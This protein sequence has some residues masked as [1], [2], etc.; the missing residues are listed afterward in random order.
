MRIGMIT[1]SLYESDNRVMRYAEALASRGDEVEVIALRKEGKP[2]EETIAGVRVF[3]VQSR[4][5]KEKKRASFLKQVLLFFIKASLLVSKRHLRRRYDLLHMHSIPDFLVFAGWMPKLMGAKVILDIHDILPE[6]Y[7]SKFGVG[8]Q[9][10]GF[11]TMLLLERASAAFSDHVILANHLWEQRFRSR[12]LARGGKCTV[13]LNYPDRSL[14][15]PIERNQL[16]DKFII[17]YPGTLNQHQGVDVAIRAFA[18]L[19]KT[20]PNAEFHIYGEGRT[21]DSLMSLVRS[22]NLG[23]GVRFKPMLPIRDIALVMANSDLAV[24]PKR[25]DSFGNEAFSTKIFEFMSVGVPVIVSE[26]R[27]DRYYFNDSVVRFFRDGDEED[28]AGCM[29]LLLGDEA[30]RKELVKSA[31][32]F[33]KP[34]DWEVNK[35]TYLDLVDSTVGIGRPRTAAAPRKAGLSEPA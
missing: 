24:V 30:L 13:L 9:S 29:H 5:F 14:F 11:K 2:K 19:K 16:S 4:S 12:S 8:E 25:Q 15:R 1:H 20:V 27:V 18:I 21:Q 3:R 22:L 23:D 32:E 17:L 7:A 35:N 10:F 28:L 31:A 34:Y 33:V 26:T 6:L